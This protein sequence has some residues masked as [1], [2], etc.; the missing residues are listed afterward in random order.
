MARGNKQ[1]YVRRGTN[2]GEC[3]T[4]VESSSRASRDMQYPAGS[5]GESS[6]SKYKPYFDTSKHG[7]SGE[8]SF[9]DDYSNGRRAVEY[10]DVATSEAG[11]R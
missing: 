1:R 8:S 11:T 3:S 2:P 6:S 5:A 4:S 9:E 10:E 7:D